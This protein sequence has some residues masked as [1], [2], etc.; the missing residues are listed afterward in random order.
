M[1][2]SAVVPL[3][4]IEAWLPRM[5]VKLK[6]HS[7]GAATLMVIAAAGAPEGIGMVTDGVGICIGLGAYWDGGVVGVGA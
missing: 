6:Q 2:L 3:P 1:P 5:S 4:H 7:D